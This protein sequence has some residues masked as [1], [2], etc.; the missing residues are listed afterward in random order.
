MWFRIYTQLMLGAGVDALGV[1]A[2]SSCVRRLR[3][4]GRG[5][6]STFAAPHE[7]PIPSL[8]FILWEIFPLEWVISVKE[9]IV[10]NPFTFTRYICVCVVFQGL[11]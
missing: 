2:L 1:C 3:A 11:F 9:L 6:P 4:P 10:K 8:V 5:K 7:S